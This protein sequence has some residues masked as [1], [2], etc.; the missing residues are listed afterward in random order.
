[1]KI[2]Q[3]EYEV[4]K[5]LDDKWEWISRDS[6]RDEKEYE[7]VLG[8]IRVFSKKPF[9]RPR[10]DHFGVDGTGMG[11]DW[12]YLDRD[13]FFFIKPYDDKPY[14]IA[15]LIEE[16]E[17]HNEP[18]KLAGGLSITQAKYDKYLEEHIK[19]LENKSEE[20]E[21]KKDTEW[22]KKE[23]DDLFN[24]KTILTVG[25]S[26]V[27]E[28]LDQLDEP[29]RIEETT[30]LLESVLKENKR[31]GKLLEEKH[32]EWL[33]LMGI[34][35]NRETENLSPKWIESNS[36]YASSDGATEEYVHVD[37]LKELLVPKQEVLSQ[38]WIDEHRE[39]TFDLDLD[40]DSET[41]FV[42]VED[43]QE[44]LVPKQEITEKQAIEYLRERN[45]IVIEKPTIPQFI[46]NWIEKSRNK[47]YNIRGVFQK[48]PKNVEKWLYSK[49]SNE[50]IIRL[51]LAY[52]LDEYE[53]EKEQRYFAK[54][55]GH[56]NIS[57]DDKYWNYCITDESLDIGDN[58][59]HADV[60]AEYVLNAT[61]DE[62]KNLGINEDNADFVEVEES[63]DNQFRNELDNQEDLK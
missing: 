60:L 8:G 13:M 1:M 29:E 2:N 5:G 56:E 6:Y 38:K 26:V 55:K 28:I 25:R 14:N 51:G 40:E 4:L 57:S 34:I 11:I 9:K 21:M 27:D 16:Y 53:V 49:D 12:L 52:L 43:L 61:K 24:G 50:K 36:V 19:E 30:H 15:E 17:Y 18:V 48:A 63:E 35:N 7:N 62:W 54:I 23:F 3:E 42:K 39:S 20:T 46:A 10:D 33:E 45:M 58:K 32:E 41:V 37:D 22:L 47:G 44:L 31:L 59:V